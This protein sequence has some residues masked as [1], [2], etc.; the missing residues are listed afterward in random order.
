MRAVLR[1][2]AIWVTASAGAGVLAAGMVVAGAGQAAAAPA[3]L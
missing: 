1:H 2:A 3:V